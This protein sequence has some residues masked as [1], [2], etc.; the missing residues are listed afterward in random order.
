MLLDQQF[1]LDE[2]GNEDEGNSDGMLHKVIKVR[3]LRGGDNVFYVQFEGCAD[4]M[5]VTSKKMM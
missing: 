4:Y 2:E 3:L 5:D 1:I